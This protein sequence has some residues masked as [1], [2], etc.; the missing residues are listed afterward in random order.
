MNTASAIS[1]ALGN[2]SGASASGAS[3]GLFSDAQQ[4]TLNPAFPGNIFLVT[5]QRSYL[6]RDVALRGGDLFPSAREYWSIGRGAPPTEQVVTTFRTASDRIPTTIRIP[7][8]DGYLIRFPQ[9]Q[10]GVPDPV[11][12]NAGS[13]ILGIAGLLG[14]PPTA[15]VVRGATPLTDHRA[16]FNDRATFALGEFALQRVGRS[17]QVDV[18][19][20]DQD[21]QIIKSPTGNDE[22]DRVTPNS[23]VVFR[24]ASDPRFFPELPTVKV[25]VS[26]RGAPTVR[27]LDTIR[28]A[29]LTT[30][31]ADRLR[32]YSRR[33]GQTRFVLGDQIVDISGYRRPAGAD[34]IRAD[35]V[36]PGI[37]SRPAAPRVAPRP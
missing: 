13:S 2:F 32:D 26:V 33:T 21:R 7:R 37:N 24:D 27:G 15:P 20:S 34:L 14:S 1:L 18:R 36:R 25:P 35:L 28:R 11:D 31:L 12:P 5:A 6:L 29:A 9:S 17:P 23:S 10:F 3:G 30:L 4:D 8:F 16:Q 22:L 19:R